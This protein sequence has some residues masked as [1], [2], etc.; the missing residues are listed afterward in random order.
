MADFIMDQC[1][2]QAI[3]QTL[4]PRELVERYTDI[5][6]K[7]KGR[8][9]W[10]LCPLHNEK[11]P[12]LMLNH[13]KGKIRCFGCDWFGDSLDFIAAVWGVT[14]ADVIKTLA[15]DLGLHSNSPEERRA[16]R[17]KI[18]QDRQQRQ[19]AA[20]FKQ[21]VDSAFIKLIAIGWRA[22]EI[23]N[24]IKHTGDLDRPEVGQAFDLLCMIDVICDDLA[25]NEP[26]RQRAGLA[27]AGRFGL[28]ET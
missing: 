13:D 19:A 2:I 4:D 1:A 28:W 27:R 18:K 11:T 7:K 6:F 3:K 5:T 23:V 26:E 24:A 10:A 25:S 21:A 20:K 14:L 17:C 15:N 8:Y 9:L 12:S 22:Q 16:I